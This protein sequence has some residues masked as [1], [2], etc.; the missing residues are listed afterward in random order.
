MAKV[1]TL[2][3]WI[4]VPGREDDFVLAW[5]ELASRASGLAGSYPPTLLRDR[6]RPNVFVTFGA[7]DSVEDVER[8]RASEDFA[9]GVA[10]IRPMLES[11]EPATL[12]EIAWR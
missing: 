10:R 2:G 4:V 5:T 11:F 8:F 6:E 3:R 7:F 9:E 1:F 12:D